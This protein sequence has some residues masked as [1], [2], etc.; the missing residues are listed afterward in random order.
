[1]SISSSKMDEGGRE[2]VGEGE[3]GEE[4]VVEWRCEVEGARENVLLGR[5]GG[6]DGSGVCVCVCVCVCVRT[7]VH[8]YVCVES[9][10]MKEC[11]IV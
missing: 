1:M 10:C 7:S 5:D 3:R 6:W 8:T 4:E 9:H 11:V 2:G